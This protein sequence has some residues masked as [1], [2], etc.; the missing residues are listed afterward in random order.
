[1]AVDLQHFRNAQ[2]SNPHR[3]ALCGIALAFY[4]A[5]GDSV[6]NRFDRQ[7]EIASLRYGN[8]NRLV[9]SMVPGVI[10]SATLG[11]D[12]W[13]V[14]V[15]ASA[16]F[17]VVTF[18]NGEF[19]TR[20]LQVNLRNVDPELHLPVRT[21]PLSAGRRRDTRCLDTEYAE[22][23]QVLL[24]PLEPQLRG[25]DGV[26]VA[27][28]IPPCTEVVIETSPSSLTE[29]YRIAVLG[30]GL[31]NRERLDEAVRAAVVSGAQHV[32]FLGNV[33]SAAGS[34]GALR[35]IL[36]GRGFTIGIT[37]GRTEVAGDWEAFQDTFGQTDFDARIGELRLLFMDSASGRLTDGQFELLESLERTSGPGMLLT[38]LPPLDGHGVSEDSWVS[39]LQ[40][41]RAL[42]ELS[43][44]DVRTLV[45]SSRPEH[46]VQQRAGFEMLQIGQVNARGVSPRLLLVE[47]VRPTPGLATCVDEADCGAEERCVDALCQLPCIQDADCPDARPSCDS[48]LGVCRIACE[49]SSDCPAPGPECAS[50]NYCAENT[51]LEWRWQSY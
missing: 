22:Q 12:A 19:E 29:V 6:D 32:V 28:Q 10:E 42:A 2:R 5:C 37:P 50:D 31:D 48:V 25:P 47:I 26:T 13:E 11:T 1:M 15:W 33:V 35:T 9:T 30:A 3:L 20:V 34:P 36:Q 7:R 38:H 16:P 4:S 21:G 44:A 41:G 18:A 39:L 27:V 51:R 45:T 14:E 43:R 24:A 49:G 17:P 8:D 46:V 40:A 23:P